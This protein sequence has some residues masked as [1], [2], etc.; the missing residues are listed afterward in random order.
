M[1]G[2][3]NLIWIGLCA[4]SLAARANDAFVYAVWFSQNGLEGYR[5][6]FV[7]RVEGVSE[8]YYRRQGDSDWTS[9]WVDPDTGEAGFENGA[10]TIDDFNALFRGTYSLRI[11]RS[12]DETTYSFE[13]SDLDADRHFPPPLRPELETRPSQIPPQFRFVWNWDSTADLKVVE[14]R[15]EDST[16]HNQLWLWNGQEGFEDLYR[17]VDF[18]TFRGVGE[19]QIIYGNQVGDWMTSWTLVSGDELFGGQSPAQYVGAG[20]GIT[21]EVI[22]EPSTVALALAGVGLARLAVRQRSRRRRFL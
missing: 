9:L 6:G 16:V 22:P 3:R 10:D 19:F 20:E 14:Y 2:T 4:T 17:D 7:M 13:L 5:G 11:L 1:R 8:A 12:S 21:F 18:G 15:S